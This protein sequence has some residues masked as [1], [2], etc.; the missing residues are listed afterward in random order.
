MKLK[1]LF[2]SPISRSPARKYGRRVIGVGC[3][4]RNPE[5]KVAELLPPARPQRYPQAMQSLSRNL[6][7]SFRM[8][9]RNPGT[10]LA[11]LLILTLGIGANSAI[12]SVTNA[13]LLRPFP[14]RNPAQLVHITLKGQPAGDEMNLVRYE[15]LRDHA[16]SFQQVAAWAE[17]NLNL[18]GDGAPIQAPVV[19]VTPDFLSMLGMQPALGRAFTA[20]EGTPQGRPVA[21]LSHSLWL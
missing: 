5:Q 20:D 15:S 13:L 12:F 10:T 16:K 8:M 3:D 18:T 14:F 4:A 6:H 21:L 9:A 17:D 11:I 1:S 19:R 2:E 7:F